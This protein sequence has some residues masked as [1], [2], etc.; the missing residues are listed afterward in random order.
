M[1]P[2]APRL[3]AG[4]AATAPDQGPPVR[5]VVLTASVGAGHDGPAREIAKRLIDAG[6]QAD[7]V[8][9]VDAHRIDRG[10]IQ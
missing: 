4:H 5:V 7:L 6:H 3:E 2:L 9:L 1:T 8:D 10:V